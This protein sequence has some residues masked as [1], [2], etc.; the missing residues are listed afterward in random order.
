MHPRQRCCILPAMKRIGFLGLLSVV[1]FIVARPS[2]MIP[3][4]VRIET[5]ALKGVTG[6]TQ[7][8]VRAFKGIPFAAPPTGDNRWKAPQP[9][10]RSPA[11]E[12]AAATVTARRLKLRRPPRRRASRLAARTAS[13]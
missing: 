11:D 6:T 8:S 1:L 10:L 12:A 7:S 5:G 13:I 4:Q 3:D 9:A 2:A